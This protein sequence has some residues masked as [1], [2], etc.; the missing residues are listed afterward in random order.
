[1]HGG[2]LVCVRRLRGIVPNQC[3]ASAEALRRRQGRVQLTECDVLPPAQVLVLRPVI[4]LASVQAN[5][6]RDTL[7]EPNEVGDAPGR[8]GVEIASLEAGVVTSRLQ[9]NAVP[10]PVEMLSPE[11]L[12]VGRVRRRAREV[13]E[14]RIRRREPARVAGQRQ[15][16]VGGMTACPLQTPPA[17]KPRHEIVV[18]RSAR[19]PRWSPG[20][21]WSRGSGRADSDKTGHPLP[22]LRQ[23]GEHIVADRFG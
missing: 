12:Q 10:A 2:S 17:M 3:D 21:G 14:L 22:D 6:H 19:T 11:G 4:K 16:A 20:R 13:V 7:V 9:V 23:I 18:H 5:S 15:L 1:M 8:P